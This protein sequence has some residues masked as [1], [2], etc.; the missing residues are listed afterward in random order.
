MVDQKLNDQLYIRLELAS[1]PM[2]AF[3][4]KLAKEDMEWLE[5]NFEEQVTGKQVEIQVLN[6]LLVRFAT[7]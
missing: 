5:M 4:A 7:S 2:I 6:D 3:Q 1:R